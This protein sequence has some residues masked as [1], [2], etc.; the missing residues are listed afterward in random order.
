[1]GVSI[2]VGATSNRVTSVKPKIN[3]DAYGVVGSGGIGKVYSGNMSG[4]GY[5]LS[6]SKKY[7]GLVAYSATWVEVTVNH[8]GGTFVLS[9]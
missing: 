3:H 4:T 1:L 9:Y 7:T 5:S 8:T 2:R 6:G